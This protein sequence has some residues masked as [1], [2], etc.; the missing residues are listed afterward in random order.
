MNMNKTESV[1]MGI[2]VKGK[3]AQ[4]ASAKSRE[5]E[6]KFGCGLCLKRP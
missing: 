2:T 1:F 5:E 6:E 4:L 3:D